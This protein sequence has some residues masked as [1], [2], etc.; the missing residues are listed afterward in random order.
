MWGLGVS[1]EEEEAAAPAAAE[2]A[3]PAADAAPS[4]SSSKAGKGSAKK[5][6]KSA[7]AAAST[8]SPLSGAKQQLG[9]LA[10]AAAK[11]YD[12]PVVRLTRLGAAVAI[13]VAAWRYGW[14]FEEYSDHFARQVSQPSIK[15][16]AKL[17]NGEVR[18]Q[19]RGF[20]QA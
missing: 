18:R 15:F 6:K 17:Q 1:D 4:S 11:A 16:K 14:A 12:L 20:G 13:V 9:S 5:D 19:Q 7:A 8:A 2:P 3:E 10:K